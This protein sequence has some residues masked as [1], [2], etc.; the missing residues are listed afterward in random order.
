[1]NLNNSKE[2]YLESNESY[3]LDLD[4]TYGERQD[5]RLAKYDPRFLQT[6]IQ[7][8]ITEKHRISGTVRW[9]FSNC[10]DSKCQVGHYGNHLPFA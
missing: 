7:E 4:L 10:A 8:I 3:R 6:S 1:M 9:V 2:I 5:Y